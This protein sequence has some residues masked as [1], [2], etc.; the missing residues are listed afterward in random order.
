MI[1]ILKTAKTDVCGEAK[2]M[3][4]NKIRIFMK[5]TFQKSSFL[6]INCFGKERK[7][8]ANLALGCKN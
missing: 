3:K 2:I 7:K 6:V 1:F 8:N 5:M 4:E